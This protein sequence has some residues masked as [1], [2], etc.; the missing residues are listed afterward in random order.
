MDRL[1]R[2]RA[3]WDSR[4][5]ACLV[6]LFFLLIMPL[7]AVAVVMRPGKEDAQGETGQQVEEGG[8]AEYYAVCEREAGNIRVP[9]EECL[10]SVLANRMEAD[11]P[12]EALRAM[13]ILLRTQAVFEIENYGSYVA[14]DYESEAQLQERWGGQ[15]EERYE[16]YAQAVRETRGIIMTHDGSPIETAYHQVSAGST[17]DPAILDAGRPLYWKPVRCG[18]DLMAENY[19]TV[20][21]FDAAALDGCLRTLTGSGPIEGVR[22][23]IEERDDAGYVLSLSV[24]GEGFD[25][26]LVGGERFRAAFGLP[27]SD[28]TMEAAEG[29][30]RFVCF[31]IGHGYGMSLHQ[32]ETLAGQG[33]D[34]MQILSYFFD[35]IE[36]MRI[37]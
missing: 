36:F 9:L 7:A 28:F 10:L 6:V 27:S 18:Q 22:I 35:E 2:K 19:R 11:A 16:A 34:C 25:G 15:F 12:E 26:M 1:I 13:A 37:A 17:R 31:G 20:L 24:E 14:E 4:L 32:A 3:T 33:Q 30:V 5:K 8:E 21:F 29:G 23:T